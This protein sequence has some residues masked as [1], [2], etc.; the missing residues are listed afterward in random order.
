MGGDLARDAAPAACCCF[1]VLKAAVTAVAEAG[2]W[3]QLAPEPPGARIAQAR[4]WL[5]LR[6]ARLQKCWTLGPALRE[7][8]YRL[9]QR[10]N[11]QLHSGGLWTAVETELCRCDYKYC[12]HGQFHLL[13][14]STMPLHSIHILRSAEHV[15]LELFPAG[16]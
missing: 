15:K 2:S 11:V 14:N 12:L 8:A 7:R 16:M 13:T 3:D 6:P 4:S 5:A 10:A 9:L 1:P